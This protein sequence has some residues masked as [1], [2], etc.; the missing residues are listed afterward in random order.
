MPRVPVRLLARLL[1]IVAFLVGGQIGIMPMTA[2]GMTMT[3]MAS[4]LDT[5]PCKG[6][7]PSKMPVADCGVVCMPMAAIAPPLP[8]SFT[9]AGPPAWTWSNE[10]DQR[11]NV[12]PDP[13]PPRS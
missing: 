8:H 1:L 4:D 10:S 11:S 7:A 13:A 12:A 5:A 9:I 6:C 2:P 3:G